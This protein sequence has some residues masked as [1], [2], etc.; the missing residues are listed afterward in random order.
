MSFTPAN[1]HIRWQDKVGGSRTVFEGNVKT[2]VG[3]GNVDLAE[4]P[5]YPGVLPMGSPIYLDEITRKVSI[6]YEFAVAEA[7]SAKKSVKIAK[8]P[9]GSRLKV[10]MSLMA[11]QETLDTGATAVYKV[12]A[13]DTSNAEYDVV[14]LDT[15]IT[16]AAD[17][18]LWEANPTASDS[19]YFVKVK[20]NG[21]TDVDLV[22]V[23][24]TYA[25]ECSCVYFSDSPIMLRRLPA[26]SKVTRKYMNQEEFCYFNWALHK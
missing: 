25:L 15:T 16:A 7:V 11:E 6:H 13:V 4:L 9:E 22:N 24:G 20:P 19:K 10:G 18:I 21:L 17:A 5:A 12:N 2:R 23:P 1:N 8:G 3:G 26:L 14:T